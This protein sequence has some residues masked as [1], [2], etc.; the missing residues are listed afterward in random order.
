MFV[1]TDRGGLVARYVGQTAPQTKRIFNKAK[2]G[3]LFI[4]EAYTLMGGDH[5]DFGYEAI[6][7]LVKEME[8]N[9]DSTIVV[10]AGYPKEMEKMIASNPGLSSRIQFQLDFPDYSVDEMLLILE[11]MLKNYKYT[12]SQEGKTKLACLF[13]QDRGAEDFANGRYVRN[14]IE[15]IM[16]IQSTRSDNFEISLEDINC[17]IA[18]LPVAQTKSAIGFS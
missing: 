9:R 17:Y 11:Q 18:E 1:E 13:E 10:F 5:R 3:M 7:T 16:M 2:G 6:A 12:I 14:I 4:D 8:D 15:K